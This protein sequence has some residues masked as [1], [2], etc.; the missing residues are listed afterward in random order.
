MKK[1]FFTKFLFGFFLLIHSQLII[2]QSDD[3]YFMQDDTLADIVGITKYDAFCPILEGDSVRYCGKAPCTGWVKDYYPGTEKLIHQG[4]Y[5]YGRISTTFTNYF[6]SGVIERTF[7]KKPNGDYYSF[8]VFDSL[9]KPVTKIEYYRTTVIKRQDFY[10]GGIME[11]DDVY[12]KKGRYIESQ[13][14]YYRNGKPYSELM[15]VDDKKNLYNYREFS[16]TGKLKF[17]GQ[18]IRNPEI[19][20]YFSHGKWAYYDENGKIIKIEN[21]VKGVLTE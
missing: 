15:L 2:A 16:K 10:P 9:S 17:A 12:E 21:Y 11:L 13:K 1:I 18:K 14:Y 19:N 6:F 8:E 20:D 4:S 3:D 5:D 7:F